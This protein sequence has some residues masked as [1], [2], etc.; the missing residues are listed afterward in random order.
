MISAYIAPFRDLRRFVYNR[1]TFLIGN[2]PTMCIQHEIEGGNNRLKNLYL[3]LGYM[4]Y[5][6][7]RKLSLLIISV[8]NVRFSIRL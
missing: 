7:E 4:K 8:A 1:V 5:I 6:H 3:A 2:P